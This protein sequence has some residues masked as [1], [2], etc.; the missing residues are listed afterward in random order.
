MNNY[1]I[2][3]LKEVNPWWRDEYKCKDMVERNYF[4]EIVIKKVINQDIPMG[5][6][7]SD[8]KLLSRL[9]YYGIKGSSNELNMSRVSDLQMEKKTTINNYFHYLELGKLLHFI[10]KYTKSLAGQSRAF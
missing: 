6:G 7:V 8:R 10:P 9:F 1:Q 4:E 5:Y 3:Y 2:A